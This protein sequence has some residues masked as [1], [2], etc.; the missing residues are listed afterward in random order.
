MY[1][2]GQGK[3]RG[4]VRERGGVGSR[5]Q[6]RILLMRVRCILVTI[7]KTLAAFLFTAGVLGKGRASRVD[8]LLGEG[9][10]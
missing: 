3:G 1:E 9:G 5:N 4:G 2:W 8:F 7:N 6:L 10:R